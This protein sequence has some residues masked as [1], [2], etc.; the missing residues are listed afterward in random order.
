MCDRSGFSDCVGLGGT[1]LALEGAAAR[2][3]VNL[4]EEGAEEDGVEGHAVVRDAVA[5]KPRHKTDP[6]VFNVADG[7]RYPARGPTTR[8]NVLR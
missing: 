8:H 1:R 2:V 7:V 5:L 6:R 3:G 4:R